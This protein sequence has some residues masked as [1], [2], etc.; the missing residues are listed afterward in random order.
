MPQ[1]RG[2][3][4][5]EFQGE[6]NLTNM[7][8]REFMKY[9]GLFST[10]SF[11]ANCTRPAD[12]IVPFTKE[13]A[14]FSRK[15]YEFYAT[16]IGHDGFAQGLLVKS[17]QGRP[18]KIEGHPL[19]PFSLGA[20]TPWAQA[21]LYD[22]YHP[23]R[24]QGYKWK[25]KKRKITE[26]SMEIGNEIK[27]WDKGE[28]V[29]FLIP[30]DHSPTQIQLI[31]KI[32]K[33][34]PHSQWLCLSPSKITSWSEIDLKDKDLVVSF[35]EDIFSD[36]PDSLKLA[37]EFMGR[38][39]KGIE[40]NIPSKVNLLYA[41]SSSPQLITAKADQ[42][43]I[44]R[45]EDIW[46]SAVDLL[47]VLQGKKRENQIIKDLARKLKERASAVFI[48]KDLHPDASHLENEINAILGSNS[49]WFNFP[50]PET[51]TE[52]RFI[53]DLNAEKIKTLIMMDS[54]LLLWRPEL[55]KAWKK[56][57]H[58]ISFS[59]WDTKTTRAS[60]TVIA[61][62]HFLEYWSDLMATDGTVSIQQPLIQP[63]F[64]SI[65]PLS[66]LSL[67]N[68]ENKDS[69]TLI[70]EGK[71]E[72]LMKALTEGSYPEKAKLEKLNIEKKKYSKHSI[73]HEFRIKTVPDNSMHF[74]ENS[75]NPLLQ[76]LP[77]IYSRVVWQNVYLL[78]EKDAL[79]L[80]LKSNDVI[81][82]KSET[83]TSSGPVIIVPYVAP[84]TL[85][86]S[87]GYGEN[88]RG[89][90]NFPFKTGE[91]ISIKKTLKKT[92]LALWQDDLSTE[93]RNPVQTAKLPLNPLPHKT[94]ASL[95]PEHPLK[96]QEE[97][98]QWG[99]T[100]DL[101]TCIG[102]QSCVVA[103]QVENNVPFVGEIEA[104][105]GRMMHWLRVDTYVVNNETY[106]QP[107]PC[108][109]CEK[110]PC[111]VV[112]P[113]N[114]T[115]HGN[116]GLNEMI[117]NRCVG[118]RYCSNNCPYRVRRFNFKAYSVLKAPFEMGFNP[119]VSVRDRGV[120]EKCT[121]CIQRIREGDIKE[122]TS[123]V[124][125]ACAQVCPTEAIKFGDLRDPK[126][127]VTKEKN[128]PRLY[129]LLEEEGTRPRTSYLKV[130]HN[131]IK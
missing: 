59:L 64:H 90:N 93:G 60:D 69:Y 20:T 57:P 105:R 101:T 71:P 128:S 96:H 21:S 84:K 107:V 53:S 56:I 50:L 83:F 81:E 98:P 99:M 113:V 55:E 36:R 18:V 41:F 35:D 94:V 43:Y 78:N 123:E 2:M 75:M 6:D 86:A 103:C 17:F 32:Q 127:A 12:K 121:Y 70:T 44:M 104:G 52:E 27:H 115:L 65:D 72:V 116:G 130:I 85:V 39:K 48:A 51:I 10:M 106:F 100:I 122:K 19:H 15:N 124:I 5:K 92:K 68:G 4:N 45:R 88:K 58:K 67:L 74:G 31:E 102:C 28:G 73:D 89:T 111:E 26:L 87:L 79:E 95:Y 109:H 14:E 47:E 126:L 125:S 118:T 91:K 30:P 1:M 13:I 9:L 117:Y 131:E 8:R 76:E 66:L 46:N 80:K 97:G 7:D 37:R 23:D 120:M 42:K 49:D 3:K 34:F 77:K 82:V 40:S 38:R 25:G 33:R 119:E 112:C 22:L 11:L 54:N 129:D 16:A 62:S 110:A 63:I 29:Y 114:A 24:L 61:R 108:M